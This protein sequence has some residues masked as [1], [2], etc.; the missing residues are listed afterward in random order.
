MF[1]IPTA[2]GAATSAMRTACR[3][4]AELN[5]RQQPEARHDQP[6]VP[7]W[8]A[9]SA[10]A[11]VGLLATASLALG[12]WIGETLSGDP[13]QPMADTDTTHASA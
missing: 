6:A 11:L 8:A 5:A 1:Q 10:P 2:H 12:L 3:R 4:A 9:R 7:R 13:A